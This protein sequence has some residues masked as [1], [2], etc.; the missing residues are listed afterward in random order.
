MIDPR[1]HSS[2]AAT[3]TR[4]H[5]GPSPGDVAEMLALVGAD[6]LDSLVAQTLPR[7]IRPGQLSHEVQAAGVAPTVAPAVSCFACPAALC[8]PQ[9]AT[10]CA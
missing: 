10:H 4:R 9:T 7:S 1:Q 5:I 3:F 2:A 8:S 6:S